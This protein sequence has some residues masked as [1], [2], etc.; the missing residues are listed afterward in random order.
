MNTNN[1][2][3]LLKTIYKNFI[4]LCK[5][6]GVKAINLFFCLIIFISCQ[7]SKEKNKVILGNKSSKNCYIYLCG[8]TQKFNYEKH[9]RQILDDIGKNISIK[10]IAIKP[11]DR[12]IDFDNMLC[13]PHNNKQEIIETYKYIKET[14]NNE[15][16]NGYIGFSNGGFFLLK[17]AEIESLNKPIIAIGA[18]GY[19]G[20]IKAKNNLFLFIGKQDKWHYDLAKQFYKQSQN[21]SLNV[22]LI[23]YDQGHVIPQKLLQQVLQN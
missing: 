2:L 5:C 22:K 14:I 19:I 7:S 9:N 11:K 10:I 15:N 8:L 16:I 23:E 13:W 12:C 18:G 3:K 6:K 21:T 20:E 4:S 1:I 17:L